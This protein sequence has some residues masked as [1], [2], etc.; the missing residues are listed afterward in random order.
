MVAAVMAVT[1]A[2]LSTGGGFAR[3]HLRLVRSFQARISSGALTE[4]HEGRV[5][6]YS[7]LLGIRTKA[8]CSYL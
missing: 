4:P 7:A 2:R 8:V 1:I 3:C 5:C 6:P